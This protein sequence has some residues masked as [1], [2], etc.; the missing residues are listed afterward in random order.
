MKTKHFKT[1]MGMYR[2]TWRYLGREKGTAFAWRR[3]RF[4][5]DGYE[6]PVLKLTP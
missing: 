4:V 6:I 2:Y 5:G 1:L 3:A